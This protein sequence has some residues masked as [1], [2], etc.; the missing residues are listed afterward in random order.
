MPRDRHRR[1]GGIGQ[2]DRRPGGGRA[3]R[4]SRYLD[5][6][7]MYRSVTFAALQR[8]VD[9]TDGDALAGLARELDI[10]VGDR[11]V[12]D[13]VDV[14]EAIRGPAVNGAVSAVAA[15]PGVRAELVRR[16]RAWAAST[17]RGRGRGTRHRHGRVP[18]R[19]TLKVFLTAGERASRAR[20]GDG[21]RSRHRA[22][23]TAST[24]PEPCRR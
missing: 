14:T 15:H 1:T 19:A 7:A 22:S 3:A 24:R 13:G 21:R 2:V 11:V 6:G 9:A 18:R 12:V 4:A 5:T 8:G 10:E 20:G 23:A 17:W 16:Q